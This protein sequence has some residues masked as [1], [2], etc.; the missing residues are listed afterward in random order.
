MRKQFKLLSLI[1]LVLSLDRGLQ[2]QGTAFTYHCGL[3]NNNGVPAN[4][5]YDIQFGAYDDPITGTLQGGLV[6]N[7]GVV[8]SNGLFTTTID[9]GSGVFLGEPLWLDIAVSTNGA[10][11]F[12]AITPRRAMTPT[13]YSIFSSE[14]GSATIA[15]TALAV[16]T[17]VVS[18]PSFNTATAPSAGQVLGFN[19]GQ[20]VWQNPVVGGNTGGWSLTGNLGTAPGV[21]F[22]GTLDKANPQELKSSRWCGKGPSAGAGPDASGYPNVIG[23]APANFASNGVVGGFPTMRRRLDQ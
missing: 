13:P 12:S 11:S 17:G 3:L 19:G 16:D 10:D 4:G 20:L 6:T 14:A 2:A 22:L 21:N 8:V 15:D 5:L 7:T 18:A 9:F 1:V 23:G